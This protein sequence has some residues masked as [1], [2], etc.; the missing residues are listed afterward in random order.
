MMFM[1]LML[2]LMI[3]CYGM[4]AGGGS[5][6]LNVLLL[7]SDEDDDGVDIYAARET[8][9]LWMLVILVGLRRDELLAEERNE[10]KLLLVFLNDDDLKIDFIYK[11]MANQYKGYIDLNIF[12]NIRA[13]FI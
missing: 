12:Y 3:V 13:F 4:D 10:I 9:M 6:G 11:P 5:L 1:M 8:M 7:F 2:M